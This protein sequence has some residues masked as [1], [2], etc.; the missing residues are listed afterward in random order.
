MAVNVVIFSDVNGVIGFG[1]YGGAYRV[2]TVLRHAGYTVQVV[3]FL[4]SWSLDEMR[5][6]AQ[7]YIDRSTLF[8]GF[9]T[10]LLIKKVKD[11][12]LDRLDRTAK[13]REANHLPQD[14][15]YLDEMF[16]IFKN[17]NPNLK[18]V[19]GGGKSAN[20]TMRGV[21]YWVWGA[22]DRSVVALARHLSESAPLKTRSARYGTAVAHADY[23]FNDFAESTIDYVREDLLFAGE[24]LPI[25]VDRGCIFRCT[26]CA[27][28]LFRKKGEMTKERSTL[29]YEMLRNYQEFGTTGYMFC[30]DTSN[31]SREKVL[32]L[33]NNITSLPFQIDWTG[34]GRVDVIHSHR[35][36]RELLM[37]TGL[38]AILFGIETLNPI[39]GKDVGKGLSPDKVKDTL[40]YLGEE[41]KGKVIMTGSFI[42]GLPGEDEDSAM[43][44]AEW[45]M[46]DDCP[47][48]T[49]IFSPLNIRS[50]SDDPDAPMS[51]IAKDPKAF[52]YDLSEAKPGTGVSTDGPYWRNQFMD[53]ARA[54]QIVHDIHEKVMKAPPIADW[55]VYSRLR[56]V[57]YSHDEVFGVKQNDQAFIDDALARHGAMFQDYKA[58]LLA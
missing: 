38:K 24:H 2:A 25:E 4:A 8:V 52:G 56:N 13:N 31:D 20:T 45:V 58:R 18:I 27:N 17:R 37:E 32:E 39:S 15:E 9:A 44:T 26:F 35:E 23:P 16:G 12:S 51:R 43:R 3:E 42:V 48:D 47:L 55:A 57:G 30:D 21:D 34:F 14:N 41:W 54:T 11:N 7:K 10:S 28:Q 6:V 53:K 40:R 50:P 29:H 22:A 36:Q 46:S 1:R 19:V 49:A 33:H 5:E